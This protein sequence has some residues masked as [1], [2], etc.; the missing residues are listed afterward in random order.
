MASSERTL[1]PLFLLFF[2]LNLFFLNKRNY[3]SNRE[4]EKRVKRGYAEIARNG[5]VDTF[6]FEGVRA[7]SLLKRVCCLTRSM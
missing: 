2:F 1:S 6:T 4:C 7:I 5:V 3:L